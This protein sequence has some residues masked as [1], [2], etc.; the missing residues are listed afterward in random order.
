MV[1][2]FLLVPQS[3]PVFWFIFGGFGEVCGNRLD[4]VF[5]TIDVFL[6]LPSLVSQADLLSTRFFIKVFPRW[7]FFL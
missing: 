3:P 4:F 1:F 5:S 2:L 6:R 7:W